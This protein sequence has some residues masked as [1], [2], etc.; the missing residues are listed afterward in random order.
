MKIIKTHL[1]RNKI[2]NFNCVERDAWIHQQAS[3][4]LADSS[5]LDVGAG[6]CPYR[7]HFSHCDYKTQDFAS[8]SP[9]QLRGREGYGAIDYLCDATQIPVP[10]ASFDAVLCTEVLEHVPE[11]IKVVNEFSRILKP[12]GKLLLTAPLG[13][14]IHQEPYH[15]Y[16]GYTPFWYQKFLTEAGFSEISIEPNGGF[17]KHYSQESIRFIQMINPWKLDANFVLRLS[18]LPFWLVLLPL[19]TLL[20]PIACHLLDRFDKDKKFT[21]GYHVVAIKKMLSQT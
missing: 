18:W 6:S 5:V 2:F 20:F 12:G 11:P 10:E 15:F 4:I 3:T 21:I 14:G 17:F 16:G 8:L 19:M 9:E 1:K 13:S 7:E